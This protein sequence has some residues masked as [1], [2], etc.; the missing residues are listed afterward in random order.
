MCR[1]RSHDDFYFAHPER[2]TG[3]PPPPP[4]LD[5]RR[6]EILQR[7]FA[8]ELLRRAFL[9]VEIEDPEVDLGT[10]VHGQFGRT[11]DWPD[12]ESTVRQWLED[13]RDQVEEVLDGLLRCTELGNRRDELLGY[14][15]E[16]LLA[17]IAA[18]VDRA[19]GTGDLSQALAENGVLP[20]FGFPTRVRYLFHGAPRS[21][22]PWPPASTIDRELEI[23]VAQFAPGA[24]VIKDKAIHVGVGVAAWEPRGG[25]VEPVEDPLGPRERI[26]YCRQCLYLQPVEEGQSDLD[27][28]PA[29]SRTAPD[30]RRIVMAEPLGFRSDWRPQDYD[31]QF[32][33]FPGTGAARISP[34][35]PEHEPSVENLDARVGRGRLYVI[36]DNGGDLFRFAPATNPNDYPGL[37]HLDLL[38]DPRYE[39]LRLPDAVRDDAAEEVAL[40]STYFTDTL[41]LAVRGLPE[42]LTLDPRDVGA[43][44]VLYSAGF[45]LREAAARQLDVQGRELR[46]GL[47]SQ[48]RGA[49]D[50]RGWIFLADALENGAGYCTQ[51]GQGKELE[52]LLAHADKYV[53]EDLEKK[54]HAA[55]CDA[56]C[57]DCLR[58][59]GN[60]AYHGLLDWRLARDWLD[61]AHDRPLALDRWT[62][63]EH[64]VAK[65]F[66]DAFDGDVTELEGGAWAVRSPALQR[67]LIVSHPLEIRHPDFL[68]E[69][70]ALAWADAQDRGLVPGGGDPE[71]VSSFDLLRRPG[72]IAVEE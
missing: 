34:K 71:V 16:P 58:E 24:E 41:L 30:F 2:I 32:E 48:P 3:D 44:S 15:G 61:L 17:D 40:G 19:R 10:N 1:G 53:R 25:D 11:E 12:H 43:R 62:S 52:R 23:A 63:H 26:D 31:G 69:R 68:S 20:M 9:R 28:C 56:S 18:A 33:W 37:V 14:A 45:M 51:L 39:D 46:L 7:V 55:K 8:I 66:R 59:Y 13:S 35:E 6:P 57:Y 27:A 47:W 5:L 72:R 22:Y 29:C 38:A 67:L 54:S 50:A 65:S 49:H 36:N 21:S 64:A 60:Q 70:L 42:E 4:Y